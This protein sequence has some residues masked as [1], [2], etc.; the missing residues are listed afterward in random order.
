MKHFNGYEKLRQIKMK[1][2]SWNKKD[3]SYM[4]DDD[5][6]KILDTIETFEDLSQLSLK[7]LFC[8]QRM[9]GYAIEEKLR[10]YKMKNS[11]NEGFNDGYNAGIREAHKE[12]IKISDR[13]MNKLK[14]D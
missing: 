3:L 13:L 6:Q 5:A 7:E 14:S 11:Y 1:H 2:K 9:V 12:I 8:L 10:Q 4:S